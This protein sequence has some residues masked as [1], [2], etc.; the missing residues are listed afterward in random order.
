MTIDDPGAFSIPRRCCLNATPECDCG[1]LSMFGSK[2]EFFHRRNQVQPVKAL[3]HR[4]MGTLRKK[5]SSHW[6]S[7]FN[8]IYSSR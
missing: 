5:E 3:F 6:M 7:G 8:H 4:V 2:A 1:P